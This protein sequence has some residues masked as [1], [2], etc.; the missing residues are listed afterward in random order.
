MTKK[1]KRNPHCPVPGCKTKQPHLASTTT[2]GLHQTFSGPAMLAL[3]VKSCIVELIQSVTD[4]VKKGR[5]FAYLTRWRQPEEMYYRAL[6]MLFIADKAAI[7]H[8]FSGEVPNSFLGMWKSVNQVVFEGKGNLD[9]P[10][11]G[12]SGQEFTA[13]NTLNDSAHASFATIV[14]CIGIQRN[15]GRASI[16]Q[17]HL[18]HWK[19]LCNYLDYIENMFRGGRT[20]SE[21]LAG[22]KNLHKNPSAWQPKNVSGPRSALS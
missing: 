22:V 1:Q 10:Q 19:T 7:P 17:K 5:F 16:V 3:W 9:R 12:L 15:P 11:S 2:Q 4:D 13:M 20:Q 14:T 8:I 21:V 18:E 6:Y